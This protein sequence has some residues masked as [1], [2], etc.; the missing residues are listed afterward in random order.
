MQMLSSGKVEKASRVTLNGVSFHKLSTV[1]QYTFTNVIKTLAFMKP[2]VN[3][4]RRHFVNVEP[5]SN[6][7]YFLAAW[8]WLKL[9][10]RKI[11]C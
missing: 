5:A 7:N 8:A 1:L 4:S 11:K 3:M 9:L 10:N 6:K 2:Q